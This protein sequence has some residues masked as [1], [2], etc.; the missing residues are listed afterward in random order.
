MKNASSH[1]EK[2]QRGKENGK[3]EGS[4]GKGRRKEEMGKKNREVWG[5]GILRKQGLST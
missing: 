2:S 1:T 4:K 3:R 5:K